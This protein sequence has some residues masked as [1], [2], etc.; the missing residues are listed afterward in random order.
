MF[1]GAQD[2][3]ASAEGA[4]QHE[5]RGLRQVEVG[6]HRLDHFEFETYFRIWVDEKV[7]R[8]RA[9]DDCSFADANGV[10][11]R[12]DRCGADSDYSAASAEGVINGGGGA[13]RDGIRLGVE[14]VILDALDPDWLE[15]SQADV[16]RDV[17]SLDVALTDSVE[18]LGC[19]VK[20]RS[21]GCHRSALL[22]IDGLVA[23]AIAEGIRTSDVGWERDVANAIENSEEI[24][25][26]RRGLEANV[27]LAESGAGHNLGLQF[28]LIAEEEAFADSDFA[29]GTNQAL[30]IVGIGAKLAGQKNFDAA[31]EEITG[32]RIS[33][34]KRLRADAFAAAEEPGGK[35]AGVVENEE[36]AGLQQL[37]EVAKQLVEIATAG[38]LEV[39]HAGAIACREG[40]LG[41]EFV[42]KVEVEIG[43]PHGFRL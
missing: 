35:D 5:Q 25:H 32:C 10:F 24:F 18:A 3:L 21:G 12:A 1:V 29:P 38:S 36:I 27:A 16:Q 28:I 4:Y 33:R 23:L 19:E 20:T 26:A 31:V 37:R 34:A 17:D 42:G 40:F 11:E 14:F 43:N 13:G 39:Q 22:G 8:C 41:D 30:P 2:V 7:G 6:Q 15:G 9:G